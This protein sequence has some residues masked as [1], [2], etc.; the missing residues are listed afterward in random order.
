LCL[1]KVWNYSNG[2]IKNIGVK[3]NGVAGSYDIGIE[4]RY[5]KDTAIENVKVTNCSAEA[6]T[7]GQCDNVFV[8]NCYGEDVGGAQY[9]LDYGLVLYNCQNMFI[10]GGY[11]SAARH[12]TS[13]GTVNTGLTG[14]GRYIPSLGIVNR[15]ITFNGM[16]ALRISDS[17]NPNNI[18]GAVDTHVGSEYIKFV[19]CFVDGGFVVAGDKITIDGCQIRGENTGLVY[20]GYMVR[21]NFDIKNNYM[22][23]SYVPNQ[24]TIGVFVNIGGQF[25]SLGF[26]TAQGGII[27]ISNNVMEYGNEIQ[28]R[29]AGDTDRRMWL[30]LVNNGY[31]GE[32]VDVNIVGNIISSGKNYPQ[33]AAHIGAGASAAA[34]GLCQAMFNTINFSNNVCNNAGGMLIHAPGMIMA[35]YVMFEGNK[36]LN[37][38]DGTALYCRPVKKSIVCKNNI[39]DGTRT[40]G[41]N[42]PAGGIES[43]I[44]LS[45]QGGTLLGW[46][47]YVENAQVSDNT[48][49]N[50]LQTA[51]LSTG[52][53]ADILV[54]H[55]RKAVTYGNVVG[56]DTKCL[57]VSTN[58]GF[59]L[60]ENITGS[61]S[62][63]IASIT[64]FRGTTQIGIGSI[65]FTANE[66]IT[67]S[68]SGKTATVNSILTT[69]S[70]NVIS[71]FNNTGAGYTSWFGRNVSLSSEGLTF[72]NGSGSGMAVIAI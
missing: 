63:T 29:T 16:S 66:I 58:S 17:Q 39:V 41:T 26:T 52:T 59:L 7:L 70:T 54:T 31:A 69:H 34:A 55:A 71:I 40:S 19:N 24:N 9:G 20:I 56:T 47:G 72:A 60:N 5:L 2:S 33:G 51:N 27:N 22:R 28:T 4:L 67:G 43:A 46:N 3:G 35:N 45:G 23:T 30:S 18:V 25:D 42:Q 8:N 36:I 32:D 12:A 11:Y 50:G 61:S 57:S 64:G 15:N 21:T 1:Y 38:Y 14:S 44:S 53:R 49:L 65:G 48:V 6:L 10:N 68:L 13:M 37:S 62:G